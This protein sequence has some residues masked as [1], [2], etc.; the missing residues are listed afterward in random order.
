MMNDPG[1]NKNSGN[2]NARYVIMTAK[3]VPSKSRR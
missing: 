1:W 3:T 2:S